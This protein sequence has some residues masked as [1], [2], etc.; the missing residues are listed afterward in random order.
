MPKLLN[1]TPFPNFRYYSTD[2][3]AR[4]FGVVVMKATYQIGPEGRLVV[5]EEQAPFVMTDLCHGAVNVSSL[6]HPS[7]I[8]PNKPRTDVIVNAI[9]RAPRGVARSTWECGVEID[10]ARPL[11]SRSAGWRCRKKSPTSSRFCVPTR[12]PTSPASPSAW[13]ARAI[14]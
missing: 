3:R 1:L 12:R 9:A 7:D 4:E 5:A 2:N 13:M 11:R 10:G 8:V 6:W 14:L